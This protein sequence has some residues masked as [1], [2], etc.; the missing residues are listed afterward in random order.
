MDDV[1]SWAYLEQSYRRQQYSHFLNVVS[2]C[3]KM[4]RRRRVCTN[5]YYS[6]EYSSWTWCAPIRNSSSRNV[7][8]SKAEYNEISFAVDVI[9]NVVF[10]A[11]GFIAHRHTQ[12]TRLTTS[13]SSSSSRTQCCLADAQNVKVCRI[14]QFI[15]QRSYS[16]EY[17]TYTYLSHSLSS[18]LESYLLLP[19]FTAAFI[20][21]FPSDSFFFFLL[22]TFLLAIPAIRAEHIAT[23]ATWIQLFSSNT[24]K[25]FQR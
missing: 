14:S 8:K 20:A 15:M 21:V 2:A 4:K 12:Q 23:R 22:L 13:S 25:H 3:E 11:F 19:L 18:I 24:N 10:V 9:D 5:Y 17:I 1:L 6:I 7:N 16:V